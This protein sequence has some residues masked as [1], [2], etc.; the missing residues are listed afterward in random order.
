[1]LGLSIFMPL[2]NWGKM[3]LYFGCRRSSEDELYRNEIDQM[4]KEGVITSY[5]PAYSREPYK[6]KVGY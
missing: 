5:Y 2:Y 6:K 1:M 3:I 4:V